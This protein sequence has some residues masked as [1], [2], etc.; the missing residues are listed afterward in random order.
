MVI[1]DYYKSL[2]PKQRVRFIKDVMHITDIGRTTIYYKLTGRS[3]WSKLEREAVE[4][5]I[6]Q[7]KEDNDRQD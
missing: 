5:Y 3:E 1:F 4:L 7:H 2:T 6:K